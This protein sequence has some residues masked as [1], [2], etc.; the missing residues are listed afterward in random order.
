VNRAMKVAKKRMIR[1]VTKSMAATTSA[2]TAPRTPCP[3]RRKAMKARLQA[4]RGVG[5]SVGA[6]IGDLRSFP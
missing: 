4:I 1:K 3:K 5:G 2:K 6:D